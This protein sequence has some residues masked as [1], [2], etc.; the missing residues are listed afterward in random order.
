[1]LV[2]SGNTGKK[3]F[4]SVRSKLNILFNLIIRTIF[5]ALEC[6]DGDWI[7]VESGNKNEKRESSFSTGKAK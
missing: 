5:S 1:M 3:K 2:L 6:L 7:F 4:V